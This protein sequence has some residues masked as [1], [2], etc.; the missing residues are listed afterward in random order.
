MNWFV[1][2]P[3]ALRLIILFMTGLWLGG[4]VNWGIY[5][6]AYDVRWIS[7]WSGPQSGALRRHWFDRTPVFG[8]IGLRRESPLHGA[9]FWIRPL[10]IELFTGLLFVGLYCWEIDRWGLLPPDLRDWLEQPGNHLDR[11]AAL[12][13]MHWEYL[14]H[15]VLICF[16]IVASFIDIDEKTIPDAVTIPGALVGLLLAAIAPSRCCRS[17]TLRR[18]RTE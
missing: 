3:Y 16:M 7:P 1:E 18:D 8:W 9:G 17:C 11:Q 2:L 13:V 5:R 12:V 15:A 6:L 14:A 4:L 10:A